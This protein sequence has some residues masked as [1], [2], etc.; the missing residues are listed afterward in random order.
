M[1]KALVTGA[2]GFI[3]SHVVRALLKKNVTVRAMIMP[4]E[5]T[6]NLEGLDIEKTEGN[7]LNKASVKQAM[8]GVDTVF[9]LAAIYTIWMR[10]W[11]GI[12]E[13]N[14]QGSRNVLWAALDAGVD[15]VVY[16]S[17]IAAIGVTPGRSSTNEDVVFNQYALGNHYVITKYLSQQ[18]ALEF[19][20]HGLDVVVVNPAF[21]FGEND[22][23]PTPTG[24]LIVD[25]L[26]GKAPF[27]F[28]GGL[29]IIDVADIARGHILAAEKGRPGE[30]YILANRNIEMKEF[31]KMVYRI[32][33]VP[34][35]TLVPTPVWL[36]RGFAAGLT[37]WANHIS[38]KTP[39]STPSELKYLS[40]YLFCDNRKA[41]EELGLELSPIEDSLAASIRWFRSHGYV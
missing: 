4:G 27:F 15:R 41:R 3:G 40:Q 25:V 14:I 1:E 30:K 20:N 31:I 5:N 2:A 19:N 33:G 26:S 28:A 6:A 18:E 8:E 23:A 36:A 38:H 13:V 39:L 16:T 7:I 32:S 10:D 11:K 9:H 29:N 34:D 24:Q 22:V 12:Y 37:W 21:P 17:S 35:K